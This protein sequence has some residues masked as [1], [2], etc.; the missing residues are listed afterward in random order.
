MNRVTF[1]DI[2]AGVIKFAADPNLPEEKRFIKNPATW[3]NNDGWQE[4]PLPERK[5]KK[6]IEPELNLED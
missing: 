6:N 2:L 5:S 4:G 1:E 3:L